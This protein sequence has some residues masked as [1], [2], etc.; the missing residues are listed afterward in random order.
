[1]VFFGIMDDMDFRICRQR[2]QNLGT[3]KNQQEAKNETLVRYATAGFPPA[4]VNFHHFTD[5]QYHLKVFNNFLLFAVQLI[6]S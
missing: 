3:R 1:M 4:C 2:L 5:D 6:A